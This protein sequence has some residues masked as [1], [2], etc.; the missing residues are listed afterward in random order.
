[1]AKGYFFPDP[2]IYSEYFTKNNNQNKTYESFI[3]DDEKLVK[4]RQGSDKS[5]Y[6]KPMEDKC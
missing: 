3:M 2:F 1:M 5:R 4:K 6:G